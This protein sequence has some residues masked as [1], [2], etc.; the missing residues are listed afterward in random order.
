MSTAEQI[1]QVTETAERPFLVREFVATDLEVTGRTVDVRVVPFGE[2]ARVAD[3]PDFRPYD[4]E[5]LPGAF[6]HQ[7]NAANRIHAKY[8]HSQHVVDVVGH[9]ISLRAERDGYH[10]ST[11][12][13]QTL[14][15]ET[16]LELLRDGALPCVSVEAKP[17]KAVRTAAGVVQRVK[18]HMTGFAFCRQGAFVG[19][20]V[21]A[22]REE[23]RD[24]VVLDEELLPVDMDEETIE[25][26]RR[27]GIALP[28]RYQAHPSPPDTPAATGTSALEAPAEET[29]PT[30]SS[31]EN[32]G[33]N[34]AE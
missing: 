3:P 17:V 11:K 20:Q 8:G 31:E 7:L 32:D 4:E 13:H 12:I 18:A 30:E 6:D 10:V 25:R 29:A 28:Q 15:G 33:G 22:I 5:W 24:E 34:Q 21:L 16:T 1:P 26:C 2:I 9:G 14:Q 19:A 23:I 27:L